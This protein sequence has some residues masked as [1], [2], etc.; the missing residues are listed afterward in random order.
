MY[1]YIYLSFYSTESSDQA[2]PKTTAGRATPSLFSSERHAV[3]YHHPTIIVYP[4][5]IQIVAVLSP[6]LWLLD[7]RL[8]RIRPLYG[9]GLE[10]IIDFLNGTA[11]LS[12]S[13]GVMIPAGVPTPEKGVTVPEGGTGI[14]GPSGLPGTSLSGRSAIGIRLA[15]LL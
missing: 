13:S 5:S 7:E 9:R 4:S 11:P 1:V 3:M 2:D 6:L 12:R 14:A 10:V 15:L 8:P